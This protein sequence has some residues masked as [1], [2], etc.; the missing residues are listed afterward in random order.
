MQVRPVR[1]LKIMTACALAAAACG[2]NGPG[3]S[4]RGFVS[5]SPNDT[6]CS[7]RWEGIASDSTTRV[8]VTLLELYAD[9]VPNLVPIMPENVLQLPFYGHRVINW[10]GAFA[11]S[12]REVTGVWWRVWQ[13]GT[14]LIAQDTVP[15]HGWP[16]CSSP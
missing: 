7:F 16:T 10:D 5:A 15:V 1:A 12:P 8:D 11:A 9:G 2:E 4:V 14:D 13:Y 6:G 3:F